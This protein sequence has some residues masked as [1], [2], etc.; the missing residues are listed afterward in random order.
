M[1]LFIQYM[2]ISIFNAAVKLVSCMDLWL[3]LQQKSEWKWVYSSINIPVFTWV[4]LKNLKLNLN[5]CRA[6]LPRKPRRGIHNNAVL[7]RTATWG[8]KLTFT[9]HL[10]VLWF[11]MWVLVCSFRK[12]KT[13]LLMFFKIVF[14]PVCSKGLMTTAS[15][16]LWKSLTYRTTFSPATFSMRWY[17]W[18]RPIHIKPKLYDL[19]LGAPSHS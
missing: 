12:I 1:F 5:F 6:V 2:Q 8:R 4:K 9:S 14:P 17:C 15:L 11:A 16:S 7:G 13:F 3:I 19:I 18:C 10:L